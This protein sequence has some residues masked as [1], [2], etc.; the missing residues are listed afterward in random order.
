MA[1]KQ[2][3]TL[4]VDE[5]GALADRL[6]ARGTSIVLKDQPD[7]QAD[8]LLAGKLLHYLIQSATLY[9]PIEIAQ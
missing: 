2:S 6:L 9:F 8:C 3:I 7:L 5:I 4:R 1:A